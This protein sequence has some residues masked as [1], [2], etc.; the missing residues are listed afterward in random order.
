MTLASYLDLQHA[1][2]RETLI[3]DIVK[4]GIPNKV[5]PALR[6]LF[7]TLEVEFQP[8]KVGIPCQE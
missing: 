2:T 7:K 4:L 3:A 6:P 5:Y 8:L 1:P